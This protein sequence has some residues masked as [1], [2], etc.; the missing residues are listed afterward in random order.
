LLYSRV[1]RKG[2]GSFATDREEADVSCIVLSLLTDYVTSSVVGA[3]GVSLSLAFG[4]GVLST[5]NPC[6][7]ALLPAF[8]SYTVK[9]HVSASSEKPVSGWQ[10]LLSGGLLGLPLTAGFLLIFL[11]AGGVLA[12]GGRL[13][14][15]VFPWLAIL[16]G[17]GLVLLG[18]WML[19]TGRALEV[20][21][22]GALAAKWHASTNDGQAQTSPHM[23]RAAWLFGLGYGLSSLGCT[24]PVF[25]LV[26]GTTI[27]SG[28]VTDGILV[29]A[30]Y[31]VG[32]A[33]VLFIVALAA[34]MLG[35]V[36]RSTILPLLRWVQPVAALLL[37]VAGGYIVW[38][39]VHAGLW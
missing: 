1:R 18:G 15:Y 22:L 12:L 31:A 20:P 9:Q 24:L 17:A 39:Q 30:S 5:L 33:L 13:L 6:G 4:A 11:A 21:G 19:F 16:V 7:F 3:T 10:H 38:Y 14:V 25:L 36:L 2:Y 37:M 27:T 35:D 28:G 23:L 29:L 8:V 34:T 32:M 26:V